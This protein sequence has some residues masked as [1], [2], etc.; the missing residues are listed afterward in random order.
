MDIRITGPQGSVPADV[1]NAWGARLRDRL[2]E[3]Y[4]GRFTVAW[5]EDKEAPARTPPAL[6]HWLTLR[7]GDSLQGRIGLAWDSQWPELLKTGTET[8][9]LPHPD[10]PVNNGFGFLEVILGVVG[11]GSWVWFAVVDWQ[12]IWNRVSTFG[13]GYDAT[14]A[15]KLEVLWLL[16]GWGLTPAIGIGIAGLIRVLFGLLVAAWQRQKVRAFNRK[17][18][19]PVLQT[20]LQE[21][22]AETTKDPNTCLTLGQAHLGE[23]HPIHPHL[24]WAAKGKYNPAEGY[25]WASDDPSSLEVVRKGE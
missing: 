6:R 12:R 23:P 10:L 20:M 18:L 4:S 9:A 11:F 22:L 3:R 8:E 16:V 13:S 2:T 7:R 5:T 19:G 1:I 25:T 17:E 21:A 15:T 24:V 14:H